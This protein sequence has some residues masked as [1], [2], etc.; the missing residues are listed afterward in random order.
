[1]ER[2]LDRIL[3]DG[4][5]IDR[6]LIITY[7][8]AA[9]NELRSRIQAALQKRLSKDPSN[10]QLRR[11]LLLCPQAQIG[12]I[13]AFCSGIL[14]ENAQLC[15][16]RPDFRQMEEREQKVLRQ[17]VL[18]ALM[19]ERYRQMQ[20]EFALLVDT[21]GAGRDDSALMK[22]VQATYDSLQS[23]TDPDGWASAQL[24][25]SAF[26]GDAGET[27]WGSLL[28]QE[29]ILT[30]DYW[31]GQLRALLRDVEADDAMSAKCAVGVR[32]MIAAAD[33]FRHAMS[34]GWDAA[35]ACEP[36]YPRTRPSYRGIKEHPLYPRY[37]GV[38]DDCKKQLKRVRE[39]F[40]ANSQELSQDCAAVKPIT[41]AL[42]LLVRDFS[43][44]YDA[45]KRQRGVLDFSDLEHLAL[46]L[47]TEGGTPTELAREI[48]QRY[49]EILVDEY[50][51]C[52]RVQ[53]SIFTAVS[54]NGQNI[55][56]VGDV[57]QSIY[58]FRLADPTIFLRKYAAYQD[59][60]APGMG[61]RI[62]LSE[63]FRSDP[64]V[65]AAVNE[66]FRNLMSPALG[67]M[68]YGDREALRPGTEKPGDPEALSVF[69][70]EYGDGDRLTME[71][72]AV[73]DHVLN[74]LH[75]GMTVE[76][77]ALEPGDIAILLRSTRGRDSVFAEALGR[78]GIS[79]VCLKAA[80]SLRSRP[81]A[82]WALSLLEL[83]DNPR[84]DIPLITA[85]RCPV[86]HFTEDR[87]AQIRC[88]DREGC[89]FDALT[90]AASTEQDCADVL[91]QL[92][93]W[94]EL[95]RERTVD[96]LL[97]LLCVRLHLPALAEAAEAGSSAD[98]E[99]LADYARSFAR[100][101]AADL[102]S[103]VTQLRE[104]ESLGS[105][106]T[107]APAAG[108]GVI[109]TTI[110]GSKGLEYPVVIL[111]DLMHQF[112]QQDL[113]A[114]LLCHSELGIGAWYTDRKRGIRYATLPRLA[115]ARKLKTE[116]LSEEMRVL[117][118]AMTRPKQKLALFLSVPDRE[119][120]RDKYAGGTLPLPA[121]L[122][123][124]DRCPGDWL[125]RLSLALEESGGWVWKHP[126]KAPVPA[127]S[128]PEA[129]EPE[130]E[131]ALV[132]E[133]RQR[134]R[135][136]Y[137][138]M[139][140]T[141]LP[142]K[143]TATTLRDT[144]SA[145]EAEDA[146]MPLPQQKPITRYDAGDFRPPAFLSDAEGLS[147]SE[148]G[149][150]VHLAMQYADLRLCTTPEGAAEALRKL[151]EL[152][153]L[154][155]RQL[156]AVS[157]EKLMRF[158]VSPIGR[159]MLG[160]NLHREF[161]FSLLADASELLGKGD[162]QVLLQGVVDCWTETGDGICLVDYKSDRVTTSS[163]AARAAEYAPQLRAYALA[164]SRITGKPVIRKTLWF[165]ATDSA[166]DVE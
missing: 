18:D 51:D 100:T 117:Y 5:D 10:R 56:M 151:G 96:D 84:Q 85:L 143:L 36:A 32:D 14:R 111:A 58:R 133:V 17:E 94:R 16:I 63:N 59:E 60:P 55:V 87:L 25:Q 99:L 73:A 71:A 74:L 123:E 90:A 7:T 102:Y 44:A 166:V 93:D 67:E 152:R 78:R 104:A 38:W 80:D 134:L 128:E 54:R 135:W 121:Q 95:S 79:A 140:D 4:L 42:L 57:K 35:A 163:Q 115:I 112:N 33:G 113:T 110:H 129:A 49:E 109:I 19:Q 122:L 165:F 29:G 138:H 81:A 52:N 11:Q 65:L 162:G 126:P 77:R 64:G 114:P 28:L 45:E 13:H 86:F 147:P 70:K 105:G 23:H 72:D 161:K 68:P 53:D 30:A 164:L 127:A 39:V 15:A 8:R 43:A 3:T 34:L 132:T 40:D 61:R 22:L 150:A 108:G 47:L 66:T 118:V 101:G 120:A 9:A 119:K 130:A 107:T 131:E 142:S 157:P 12:T 125:L 141:M 82:L 154:T 153:L 97:E 21:L 98:L 37:T 146:A 31:L 116:A 158:V 27:V 46:H 69:V 88:Y 136:R 26:T 62:L 103:F 156:E 155:P 75:S 6:F 50:Q 144:F 124:E 48:S 137:T 20:P 159:A 145:V 139:E 83:I 160:G 24:A 148:K 1:M 41:D 2:L 106:L 91:L 76:G 92:R 149:T 89:F